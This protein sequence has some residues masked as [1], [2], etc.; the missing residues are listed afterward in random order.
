MGAR[1]E[2]V[3]GLRAG[4]NPRWGCYPASVSGRGS[5]GYPG[6]AARFKGQQVG[7]LMVPGGPRRLG[8]P[9]ARA[10]ELTLLTRMCP[11]PRRTWRSPFAT[12]PPRL[13][14]HRGDRLVWSGFARELQSLAAGRGALHGG[15]G[16]AGL[17]G[18][19]MGP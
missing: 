3:K 14:P 7:V 18:A 10:E 8:S 12:L 9:P 11:G 5:R 13:R 17:A 19:E 1:E 15:C 4:G 6:L 2:R 16:L